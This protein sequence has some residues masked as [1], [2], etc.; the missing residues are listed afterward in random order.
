MDRRQAHKGGFV[1]AVEVVQIAAAV[2]ATG[3]AV[4]IGGDRLPRFDILIVGEIE[5]AQPV[6]VM[7]N[8]LGV[9][10]GEGVEAPASRIARGQGRVESAVAHG[11]AGGNAGGMT[12]AKGMHG[13]L[14]RH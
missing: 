4:T 7:G 3:E 1:G 6:A 8:G 10:A 13:K 5:K 11:G 9:S 12:N 14:V 2:V